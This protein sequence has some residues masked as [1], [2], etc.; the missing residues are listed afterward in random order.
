MIDD[1]GRSLFGPPFVVAQRINLE[2]QTL[3]L[4]QN[5]DRCRAEML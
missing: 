1:R 3:D 2:I 5:E 4:L